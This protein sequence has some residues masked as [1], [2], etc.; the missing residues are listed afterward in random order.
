MGNA[1]CL[2]VFECVEM[3]R[4]NGIST[5]SQRLA[6]EIEAGI[7]PF[8]K[9]LRKGRT[10]RRTFTIYRVDFLDWLNRVTSQQTER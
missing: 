10:G 9:V 5:S 1:I 4:Q 3:M 7:V 6:D 8:G 2:T